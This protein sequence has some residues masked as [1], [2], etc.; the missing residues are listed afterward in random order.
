MQTGKK[1]IEASFLFL[2][3]GAYIQVLFSK[4]ENGAM[5]RSLGLSSRYKKRDW[6]GGADR[7]KALRMSDTRLKLVTVGLYLISRSPVIPPVV[8]T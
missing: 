5:M 6:L 4:G 2:L 3:A 1:A 7:Y 8:S